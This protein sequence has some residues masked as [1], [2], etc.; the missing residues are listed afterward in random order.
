VLYR[1]IGPAR[2]S[3]LQR[4]ALEWPLAYAD[5]FLMIEYR[6]HVQLIAVDVERGTIDFS[7]E[8]SSRH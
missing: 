6:I 5:L 7:K 2:P 1:L 4:D 8:G 3:P